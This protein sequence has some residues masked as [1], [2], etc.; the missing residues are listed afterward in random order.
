MRNRVF[1][2]AVL[3]VLLRM[4]GAQY[5]TACPATITNSRG[6]FQPSRFSDGVVYYTGNL[7]AADG[8]RF[9]LN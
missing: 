6:P 2:L 9:G 4:A 3:S 7:S 8:H 1:L 5:T